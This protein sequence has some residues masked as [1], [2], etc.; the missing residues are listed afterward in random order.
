MEKPFTEVEQAFERIRDVLNMR[1]LMPEWGRLHWSLKNGFREA[2]KDCA[3]LARELATA[4]RVMDVRRQA[5]ELIRGKGWTTGAKA[6]DAEGIPRENRLRKNDGDVSR[7]SVYGA[8]EAVVG[9]GDGMWNDILLSCEKTILK[10]MAPVRPT[11]PDRGPWPNLIVW[12]NRWCP[13]A[14]EMIAMLL[15]DDSVPPRIRSFEDWN[16]PKKNKEKTCKNN[17]CRRER[18][19]KE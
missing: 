9:Q 15:D 11:E 5:A 12:N 14:D 10:R 13:D 4:D 8:L 7:Y 3:P 6:L 18:R 2:L 16:K 17:C 1:S 19:R